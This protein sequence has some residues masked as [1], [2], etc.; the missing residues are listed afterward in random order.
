MKLRWSKYFYDLFSGMLRHIGTA[1][2][3]WGGVNVANATG[4]DIQPL[5]WKHLVTFLIAAGIIPAIAAF[6]QK[7]PLP[8]VE[9]VIVT[10][11]TKITTVK[12]T[13]PP[14]APPNPTADPPSFPRQP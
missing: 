6:L 1:L 2:A 4:V 7:T 8:D 12:P 13:P 11:E 3:G 10:T 5:N 14:D 9:E